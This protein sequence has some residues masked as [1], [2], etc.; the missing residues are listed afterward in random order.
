MKENKDHQIKVRVTA[1]QKEEIEQYCEINGM[2]ISQFLR[3]AI[4]E[5]LGGRKDG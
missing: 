5:I 3:M 4:E 1:L 2:T